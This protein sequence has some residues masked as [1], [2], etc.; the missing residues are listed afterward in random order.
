MFDTLHWLLPSHHLLVVSHSLSWSFSLRFCTLL[1]PSCLPPPIPDH[2]LHCLFAFAAVLLPLSSVL[3][4]SFSVLCHSGA[5]TWFSP[6]L[7]WSFFVS[8]CAFSEMGRLSHALPL[9]SR[10]LLLCPWSLLL[11]CPSAVVLVPSSS[12][13]VSSSFV[14]RLSAAACL[15]PPLT[16][17]LLHRFS[18]FP[19]LSWLPPPLL[20]PS[21]LCL[22]LDI[23]PFR[24]RPSSPTLCLWFPS[25]S[26]A[27]PLLSWLP[28]PLSWS[29]LRR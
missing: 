8:S 15:P 29:L 12:V 28:L 11:L 2:F 19:F 3:V 1:L 20:T 13:L 24:S 7:S 17:S 5:L 16:W 25:L 18:A 6:S 23:V 27:L 9:L 4:S 10:S 26:C 14:L 22:G 21:I